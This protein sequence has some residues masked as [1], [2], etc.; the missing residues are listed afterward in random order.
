MLSS[1]SPWRR[2]GAPE[3]VTE[4]YDGAGSAHMRRLNAA[5]RGA[6]RDVPFMMKPCN[7]NEHL[8][9]DPRAPGKLDADVY[10]KPGMLQRLRHWID[11][12]RHVT[13]Q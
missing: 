1:R 9:N 3:S 10:R 2:L 5:G 7:L 8:H 4:I 12:A 6:I 13:H 11:I